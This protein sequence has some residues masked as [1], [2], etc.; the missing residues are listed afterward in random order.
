M[1][2]KVQDMFSEAQS[3]AELS[4]PLLLCTASQFTGWKLLHLFPD[5]QERQMKTTVLSCLLSSR[6]G[7]ATWADRLT[8][9]EEQ[10]D[11]K[12]L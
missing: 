5:F 12:K 10:K 4:L 11:K 1:L 8:N 3:N 9:F 6:L 2:E 7:L